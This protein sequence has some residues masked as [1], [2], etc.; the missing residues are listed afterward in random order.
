MFS[1]D[2]NSHSLWD[3]LPKVQALAAAGHAVTHFIEDID[4]AFTSMGAE[5]DASPLRLVRERFHRSGGA[6][7]GAA[8]FYSEFLGRQA[9]EVRQWEP[10]TGQKTA[11]PGQA[12][13]P[14]RQFA[15]RRIQPGR[16][17]AIGRAQ[18]CRRRRAPPDDRGPDDGR[19]GTVP[20]GT[21]GQG[22]GQHAGI[23]PV[24]RVAR[25]D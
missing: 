3:A 23:V 18:L 12:A 9:V 20:A 13:R 22:A 2:Q 8:L 6:D 16:Q 19:G 7:W 25:A 1:I 10:Y 14:E 17:L 11:A 4:V 24:G 5:V 21:A 15:L